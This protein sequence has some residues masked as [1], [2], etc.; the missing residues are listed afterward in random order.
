MLVLDSIQGD[1]VNQLEMLRY[2]KTK[3]P[4][5]E[6]IGGNVVTQKQAYHLM[7][8]GVDGLR[9]GMG[10]GSICTTQDVRAC[11]RAQATDGYRVSKLAREYGVPCIADGG[12]SLSGHISKGLA[13]GASCVMMSSLLAGT[14]ES[15]GEYFF[16][17]GVRLKK[18]RGIC[19]CYEKRFN[20]SV[21]LRG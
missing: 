17:D 1:S 2:D 9:V 19:R 3:Y 14:E 13:C 16:K 5:L 11:G 18:Q 10:S 8:T 15:P 20:C 7:K 6:V 21:L 4:N 12:V